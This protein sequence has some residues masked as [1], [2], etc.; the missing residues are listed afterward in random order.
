MSRDSYLGGSTIINVWQKQDS[1]DPWIE[2]PSPTTQASRKYI[3]IQTG[4]IITAVDQKLF[5]SFLY[6]RENYINSILANPIREI[7]DHKD[8]LK[9][10]LYLSIQWSK[11][12]NLP[13]AT[14]IT[15]LTSDYSQRL[16]IKDKHATK[17]ALFN[18]L[19]SIFPDIKLSISK[20][21]YELYRKK[22]RNP[23]ELEIFINFLTLIT[24]RKWDECNKITKYNQASV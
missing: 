3:K 21:R 8:F 17:R 16:K 20:E 13:L 2:N 9:Y 22:D 6:E 10:F 15:A 14:I 18:I 23:D 7:N 1:F 5:D 4:P 19:K 11:K 24:E 12:N